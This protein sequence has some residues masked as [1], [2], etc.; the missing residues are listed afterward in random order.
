MN[1]NSIN[2]Q[3]L[4]DASNIALARL[5]RFAS[6]SESSI[7]QSFLVTTDRFCGIR[8]EVGPFCARWLFDQNW[9][10]FKRGDQVIEQ[11]PFGPDAE[12]RKAA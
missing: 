4:L 3:I 10:E 12:S 11:L 8:F 5:A 2:N 7:R 6:Q 9:I 1:Q